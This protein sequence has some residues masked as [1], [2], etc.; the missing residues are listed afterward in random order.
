MQGRE[1][2]D[3]KTPTEGSS[4][5]RGRESLARI[6]DALEALAAEPEVEIQYGPPI[7]PWC[8][9]LDPRVNLPAS[10]SVSGQMSEIIIDPTC[11]KC[12]RDFFIV[13][14][15]YSVHQ[16]RTTVKEEIDMRKKAGVWKNG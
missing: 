15:S 2:Q 1:T 3:Q 4:F 8:G 6:A 9:E 16:N 14:E 10:E 11:I 5:P 13:I 12:G 7:C